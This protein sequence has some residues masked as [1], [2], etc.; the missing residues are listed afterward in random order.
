MPKL[1]LGEKNTAEVYQSIHEKLGQSI[2]GSE[3]ENT[4]EA[5]SSESVS[6]RSFK[7]RA[8]TSDKDSLIEDSS[9][10][11][12]AASQRE[13]SPTVSVTSPSLRRHLE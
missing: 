2:G 12:A 3:N 9:S 8:V 6:V 1:S 10:V 13:D 5:P 4:A 11:S 7:R